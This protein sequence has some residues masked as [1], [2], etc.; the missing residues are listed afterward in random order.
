VVIGAPAVIYTMP[1]TG[2]LSPATLGRT[3]VVDANGL[4]DANAV[5][6]G[7]T[8]SGTAQTARDIGASVLLS[9]GT[10]TGQLDFTSGVVKSNLAQILG[11]A[12]TE[13]AG[14]LAAAFKKFFNI[15]TPASTRDALTLVAT[16]TNLTNAPTNGDLTATM[17][18]SVTAAVPTVGAI[19]D[20]V[21]DEPRADHLIA[22]SVGQALQVAAYGTVV[23]QAS[24]S[25]V[26]DTGSGSDDTYN[27]LILLI[28]EGAGKGQSQYIADYTG[29]SKTVVTAAAF[30]TGLDTSSKY[31]IV[32]V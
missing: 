24:T 2:V 8:G 23:S 12:L 28:T 15:A 3:A 14:Y 17:K 18:A 29:V 10:G 26:I 16:A 32:G 20:A 9:S 31:V 22:G 11:T 7:P 25:V 21:L 6:V 5:K 4:I 30:A 1:T 13:T 19:A 27:G